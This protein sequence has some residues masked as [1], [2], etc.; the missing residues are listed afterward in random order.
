VL[1][2]FKGAAAL[3]LAIVACPIDRLVHT[4]GGDNVDI[5]KLTLLQ[6]ARLHSALK[7]RF[8]R[9]EDGE[10]LLALARVEAEAASRVLLATS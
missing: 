6:L 10:A 9:T 4:I 7:S 3:I 5:K 2:P 8:E 1:C